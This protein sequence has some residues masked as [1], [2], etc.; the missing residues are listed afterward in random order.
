[1]RRRAT[2]TSIGGG[3]LAAA[4]LLLF[5][6]TD[7]GSVGLAIFLVVPLI[8]NVFVGSFLRARWGSTQAA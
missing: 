7:D 4:A 1:M 8:V 2:L 6:T 5:R 3:V